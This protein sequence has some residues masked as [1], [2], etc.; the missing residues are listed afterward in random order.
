MRT[1]KDTVASAYAAVSRKTGCV[2]VL[3]AIALCVFLSTCT[4]PRAVTIQGAVIRQ[5]TDANKQLPIADVQ[6]II[7]D[8][9][10]FGH[11][12]SDS[13]GYFKLTLPP[14]MRK[15]QQVTI[16]FLHSGYKP[17][18]Q[19]ETVSN[20]LYIARLTPL[21]RV[22]EKQAHAPATKVSNVKVRY[23]V[24]ATTSVNVGSAVRTFEVENQGDVS[25]NGQHPCSPDG[26]WKAALGSVTLD[27][28]PD[29]FFRDARAACI[30]GPCPFTRLEL[31]GFPGGERT[32]KVKARDWSD[33]ATFL[34]QAEVF[35]P[36]ISDQITESY[37]VILGNEMNFTLPAA[38]EG[39]SLEAD[40]GGSAVVFPL[41]PDLYLTWA[42]CSAHINPDQTKV[43]RCE[44][45]PGYQF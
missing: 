31:E 27:A 23:S 13:S 35:H 8:S 43:Y 19:R 10:A 4:K 24:K 26:K 32:L 9:V 11:T 5:D 1:R 20:E 3:F 15:G 45:N 16:T 7:G 36:M 21:P 12:R 40:L 39:I 18:H 22:P 2:T 38:A 37:P 25:C 14:L 44:L 34:V 30:A 17:L 28:G 42:Q 41:G 29:N 33:T 6:V